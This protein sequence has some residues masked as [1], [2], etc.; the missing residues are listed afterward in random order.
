MNDWIFDLAQN[1]NI[2]DN[3]MTMVIKDDI[4]AMY[5]QITTYDDR[6]SVINSCYQLYPFK[7]KSYFSV[8]FEPICEIAP[9]VF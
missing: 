2:D 1:K 8:Y 7:A 9:W 3:G 4:F 5:I 6:T